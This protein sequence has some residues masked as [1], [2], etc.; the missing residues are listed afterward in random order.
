[1]NINIEVSSE[2]FITIITY[3]HK[4]FFLFNIW[5]HLFASLNF[6]FKFLRWFF[7]LCVL[8]VS[9]LLYVLTQILHSNGLI[10]VW[11]LLCLLSKELDLDNDLHELQW[12][13][14]VKCVSAC[15]STCS[16]LRKAFLQI[17]HELPT[18]LW[19]PLT[20]FSIMLSWR[21]TKL[22]CLHVYALHK[23]GNKSQYKMQPVH[24]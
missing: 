21:V 24:Y 23:S 16:M 14:F 5:H 1:M 7:V 15:F 6:C 22:Q 18:A 4:H 12:F 13:T 9:F 20:C 8:S 11:I 17:W 19:R 2:D 10:S 3:F